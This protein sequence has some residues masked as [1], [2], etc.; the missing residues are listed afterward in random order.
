MWRN[1]PLCSY[2]GYH[3]TG[4]ELKCPKCNKILTVK[5]IEGPEKSSIKLDTMWSFYPFLP[6][7][8]QIISLHEGNTPVIAIRNEKTIKGLKIKLEF[9]NPTGSF[10]DRASSLITSHAL[11]IKTDKIICSSTGSFN[12]SLAAYSAKANLS[13]TSVVPANLELSKIEQMK[14]YGSNVIEEG[15]SVEEAFAM[16]KSLATREGAYL[17]TTENLLIIEGQKTI[18]LEIAYSFDEIENIIIPRGS[19]S[20]I[21]SIYRGFQDALESGWIDKLPRFFS[22]SLQRTQ[23]DYLAESL[24]I[25]KHFL[26]EKVNQILTETGGK[27]IEI[28]AGKMIDEAL[29]LA[30]NEGL[31]VEPASASVIT[32]TKRIK[33]EDGINVSSTFAMLTGSGMNA[34][35]VIASRLRGI[36]KAVW[37]LS[38][39]S[40]TKFEILNLLATKKATH[41]YAIW[42]A[43][44]KEQSLQSIYQHLNELEEKKLVFSYKEKE[45]RKVYRLTKKGLEAYTKMRDLI[46][47]I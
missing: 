36:K 7:F 43:L 20:L 16:S 33:E 46:D 30:K 19:G 5:P 12:I 14:V 45:R 6:T 8:K 24:K 4:I 41:G 39:K 22:V 15:E 9:R 32:A 44:E 42:K 29:S 13:L 3:T 23:I 26:F 17:A 34:L 35:N 11:D 28:D 10:R 2:C 38:E 1:Q 18:G 21:Y 47:Y 40:T 37:G 25:K 31:F 27:E